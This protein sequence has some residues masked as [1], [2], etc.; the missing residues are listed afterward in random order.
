MALLGV[1]VRVEPSARGDR[2]V[3]HVF[4]THTVPADRQK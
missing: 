3:P 1:A 4:L 2:P